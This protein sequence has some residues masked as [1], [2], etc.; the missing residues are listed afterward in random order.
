[1]HLRKL[2]V[3]NNFFYIN[4]FLLMCYQYSLILSSFLFQFT[5]PWTLWRCC[6]LYERTVLD[7]EWLFQYV[8]WLGW[9]GW[10]FIRQVGKTTKPFLLH[11]TVSICIYFITICMKNLLAFFFN[12]IYYTKTCRDKKVDIQKTCFG[13]LAKK[14][15]Q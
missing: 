4:I 14:V 12:N 10:W 1:M 5:L 2:F 3:L 15:Y 6:G 13:H 11:S 8:L 9:W 7:C